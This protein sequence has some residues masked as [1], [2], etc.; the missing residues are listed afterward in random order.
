MG[1][2]P[3]GSIRESIEAARQ[4]IFDAMGLLADELAERKNL[5]QGIGWSDPEFYHP[6]LALLNALMSVYDLWC[7]RDGL[8]PPELAQARAF[9][10]TNNKIVSRALWGE[11]SVPQLLA[12]YWGL[13]ASD[14]TWGPEYILS[15]LLSD[16]VS[17]QENDVKPALASPY[18]SIEDVF[19]HKW[20]EFLGTA[21]D[22]YPKNSGKHASYFAEGLLHLLVRTN[23]KGQCKIVW[24]DFTRLSHRRFEVDEPWQFCTVRSDK[25]VNHDKIVPSRCEWTDLQL[26]A[27]LCDTPKVPESLRSDPVILLLFVMIVPQRATPDVI[28]FLGSAFSEIWFLPQ[29]RPTS[30]AH[31]AA[32]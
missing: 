4:S 16:V 7:R 31:S 13:S 24:P 29:P 32:P 6:R 12:H 9:F 2:V 10:T 21:D 28:R 5:I 14:P 8:Y 17:S 20:H 1:A 26:Q 18:Y 15:N 19:R 25:G 3:G 23:L 27:S 11:A 22:R 30:T